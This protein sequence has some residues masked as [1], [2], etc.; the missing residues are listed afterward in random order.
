MKRIF[1]ALTSVLMAVA[2]AATMTACGNQ[3]PSGP[4]NGHKDRDSQTTEESSDHATPEA[5]ADHSAND[6]Q[7]SEA[8]ADISG[9]EDQ[10]AGGAVA[11]Q[12]DG[13]IEIYGNDAEIGLATYNLWIYYF[14]IISNYDSSWENLR[15]STDNDCVKAWISEDEPNKVYYVPKAEGVTTITVSADHKEPAVF[16]VA[17]VQGFTR[18]DPV[19]AHYDTDAN[20]PYSG[21]LRCKNT[22]WDLYRL[23]W[24]R[25]DKDGYIF[26]SDYAKGLGDDTSYAYQYINENYH[27]WDLGEYNY[28]VLGYVPHE[29]ACYLEIEGYTRA[30]SST[31]YSVFE[32]EC[33]DTGIKSPVEGSN[34]Y[35]ARTYSA[36]NGT[37]YYIYFEY[38]D[39]VHGDHEYVYVMFEENAWEML[40]NSVGIQRA[41]FMIFNYVEY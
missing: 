18:E 20:P 35:Y 9:K 22:Y 27:K 6:N 8:P 25:A 5:Q 24:D 40:K 14:A 2:I 21:R 12:T 29:I 23:T 41:A 28:Y 31:D 11:Q 30:D 38:D 17:A 39:N 37:R 26:Y 32:Y 34:L 1:K 10:A 7:A 19:G 16:T 3:E 15:V 36:E 4:I 33:E 13:A